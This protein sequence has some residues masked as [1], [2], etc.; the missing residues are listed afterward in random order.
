METE[1]ERHSRRHVMKALWCLCASVPL[2]G[3]APKASAD[4]VTVTVTGTVAPYQFN[5][6][7]FISPVIDYTGIFG[8]PGASLAGDAF[9]ILWTVDT[10]CP[11]C[12]ASIYNSV[13]GGSV[14]GTASPI[15]SAVLT[16]NGG[17]VT[18]G[19]AAELGEMYG[20]TNAFY[21]NVTVSPANAAINSYV[22]ST[23]NNLPNSITQPFS[24]TLTPGIDNVSNGF[25]PNI[26]GGAF[27]EPAPGNPSCKPFCD[28]LAGY[29]YVSTITLDNLTPAVPGPIAGAGLP[30][31]ILAS[32]GLLGWWR[33]RRKIG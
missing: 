2:L 9:T 4:I 11:G 13:S 29:F 12:S 32:G 18:Y 30:G 33:R 31:L 27:S 7:Y 21:V 14:S 25:P 23:A 20:Y 6:R 28:V 3:L 15:L 22:N 10:S 24:Y 5:N 17:S 1:T 19:P 16:I 26:I 8:Q